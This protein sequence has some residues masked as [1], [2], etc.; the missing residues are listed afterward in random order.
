MK[1][2]IQNPTDNK[3]Y[4]KLPAAGASQATKHSSN[5]SAL[6]FKLLLVGILFWE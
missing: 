1:I 2:D 5:H 3:G 4:T 6:F